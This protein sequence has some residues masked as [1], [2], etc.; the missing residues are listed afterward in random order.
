MK[1]SGLS[2][3]DKM[4]KKKKNEIQLN[5]L[6][7]KNKKMTEFCNTASSVSVSATARASSNSITMSIMSAPVPGS[8]NSVPADSATASS[9][10]FMSAP[11]PDSSASSNSFMSAPVPDS[12]ASSNSFM[13]APVPG[14]SNSVSADSATASSNSFM[15]APVPGSSASSNSLTMSA[16]VPGNS[17]SVSADSATASSSV[18]TISAVLPLALTTHTVNTDV[19]ECIIT[20]DLREYFS[21]S[22]D[23]FLSCQHMDSDFKLSTKVLPGDTFKFKRQCTKSLFFRE[24]VNGEK[25]KRDWICYSPSTGKVFCAHCKLFNS[26]CGIGASALMSSGYDDWKHAARD[27][28][29]HET[30]ETH[31]QSIETLL[32]RRKAGEH[33]SKRLT[34][35][36]E[37]EKKYCNDILLRIL[38]VIKMLASRGL[39]FRDSNEIVGSVHNGNYLGCLELVAE[40]DPLLAEHIQ[41][42]ANKGRGHVSYLSSTICDEFIHVLSRDVL[43]HILTEIIEAKYFAVSVDSTPHISHVDQLT[44]IFRYMTSKGPVERFVTF[45]PIEEHTGEGLATKLLDFMENTRISIKD[46]RGQ[47]Y[48]NAANMSGRFNGMQAKIKEHN[49]LAEYIPCCAHS[50]NLVGQCAVGCCSEAVTFFDFVNNLFVFFS[51]STSRW[52]RL[53]AVL[54]P[55]NM[56]TLKRLSDTRWS[57]HYDAVHSLQVGYTQVKSTLDIMC[58]DMS[59]KP[60]TQLEAAGLKDIMSHHETGILVQ[61]WS[62]ILN[63]F[64]LTSNYLQGADMDLNTATELLRSLGDFVHSLRSQFTAFKKKGKDLGTDSYKGELRRKRKRNQGWDYGDSEYLELSPSDKFKV[65]CFLPIVD[66]LLVALK[67]MIQSAKGLVFLKIYNLC[68]MMV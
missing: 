25:I 63:R 23:G 4:Q 1:R 22:A 40:F 8:A 16:P 54:K 52:N 10:S 47:S 41:K 9:N 6:L 3:W 14:N 43:D 35:Q 32:T 56:P 51:A 5:E 18:S 42:R 68:P 48:D 20:D 19:A 37:S 57:A 62:K 21:K 13:S 31:I 2:G 33:I 39:S 11:V 50:L 27:L 12:S 60:E 30:S 44:I 24:K 28:A 58:Q 26:K 65:Q 64:N 29:R 46:C 67:H 38:T 15:S 55:L 7:N 45:I 66:Q 17:N 49:N 61:L 59:Q 53:M 34:E 36:F